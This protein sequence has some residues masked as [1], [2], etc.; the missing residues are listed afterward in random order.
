MLAPQLRS[1]LTFALCLGPYISKE[2]EALR[3]SY[4]QDAGIHV[5]SAA[6]AAYGSADTLADMRAHARGLEAEHAFLFEE[7]SHGAASRA[8]MS[9]KVKW[10]LNEKEKA[11]VTKLV[12]TL[13]DFDQYDLD[14]VTW[15]W[16]GSITT[17]NTYYLMIVW[18][19]SSSRESLLTHLIIEH[20]FGALMMARGMGHDA[21]DGGPTAVE[22][23]RAYLMETYPPQNGDIDDED[24]ED[25]H[26]YKWLTR[27]IM[28]YAVLGDTDAPLKKHAGDVDLTLMA[29]Q[30]MHAYDHKHTGKVRPQIAY[31]A[32]TLDLLIAL[33]A[34]KPL[35]YDKAKADYKGFPLLWSR[36]QLEEIQEWCR[37]SDIPPGWWEQFQT[38]Y[39]KQ[40]KR[41]GPSAP[42]GPEAMQ[43]KSYGHPD[44]PPRLQTLPLLGSHFIVG[45]LRWETGKESDVY[46]PVSWERK[47]E[48]QA[49][50]VMKLIE[51]GDDGIVRESEEVDKD[52][53]LRAQQYEMWTDL[54]N[55]KDA[56]LVKHHELL[57]P[58]IWKAQGVELT[59]FISWAWRVQKATRLLDLD[60]DEYY[61]AMIK[62]IPS[63]EKPAAY[64]DNPF[65]P[66]LVGDR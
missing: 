43:F 6:E 66:P 63:L 61:K 35:Y 12:N 7:E 27:L 51:D 25:K 39:M 24:S 54:M 15:T 21:T 46:C 33:D 3:P 30:H 8:N 59:E 10:T 41:Y 48:I 26:W 60:R 29:L 5:H 23:R 62:A 47:A 1:A 58:H 4:D 2:V 22:R 64:S 31:S 14:D 42:L 20:G 44:T 19:A 38:D 16:D 52:A 53:T 34:T 17:D 45:T 40:R 18:A 9:G 13:N 37:I 55:W 57:A 56:L 28:E 36:G 65:D 11:A 49:I 32:R 50:K